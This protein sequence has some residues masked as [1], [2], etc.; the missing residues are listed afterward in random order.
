MVLPVPSVTLQKCLHSSA[1]T[2][3]ELARGH[4]NFHSSERRW[5]KKSGTERLLSQCQRRHLS[6]APSTRPCCR[7]LQASPSPFSPCPHKPTHPR[8]LADRQLG[9]IA[10][11]FSFC[12]L[13]ILP[14]NPLLHLPRGLPGSPGQPLC[15]TPLCHLTTQACRA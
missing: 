11:A 8:S 4:D 15:C 13:S 7:P 2:C 10:V 12:Q 6:C 1:P 9:R 14:P 5:V 3:S